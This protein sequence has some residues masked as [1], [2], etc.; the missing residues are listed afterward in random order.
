LEHQTVT[1]FYIFALSFGFT[2]MLTAPITTTLMGRL[3][4]LTHLGL[5]M[6]VI[7]TVHHLGGGLWAYLGGSSMG[8]EITA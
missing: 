4:G 8:V 6:V 5:I 3:Y 7:T 1:A 2:M